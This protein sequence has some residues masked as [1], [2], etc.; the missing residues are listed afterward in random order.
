MTENAPEAP[1]WLARA[2]PPLGCFVLAGGVPLVGGVVLWNFYWVAGALGGEPAA[3]MAF[4]AACL[5]GFV[6]AGAA[7]ARVGVG[8]LRF[9]RWAWWITVSGLILLM[10]VHAV[11]YEVLDPVPL[12]ARALVLGPVGLY[13]LTAGILWRH[14][15]S[16]G[17]E[18][19]P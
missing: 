6:A 4:A 11:A 18:T 15:R 7:A 19:E 17:G 5:A 3:R 8:L 14:R 2:V 9:T 16:Y 1:P 12:W 10:I 13:G